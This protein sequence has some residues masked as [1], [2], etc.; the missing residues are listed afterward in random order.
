MVLGTPSGRGDGLQSVDAAAGK[1][2]NSAALQPFV[3]EE[4]KRILQPWRQRRQRRIVGRI[5]VQVVEPES[6]RHSLLGVE[7]EEGVVH[8]VGVLVR[9]AA[10]WQVRLECPVIKMRRDA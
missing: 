8:G 1:L 6:R 10:A 3:S 5:L 2:A 4:R 9:D 7:R